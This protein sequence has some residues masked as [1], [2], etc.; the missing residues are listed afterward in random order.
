MK[1]NRKVPG[2]N[3]SSTADISFILLIFFLVTTSMDTDM[4]ITRRLPEWQPNAQEEEAKVKERNLLIVKVNSDNEILV[5]KDVIKITELKDIAK[6]FIANPENKDN[7]PAKEEYEIPG[8]GT[9]VTTTK[10]VISL[11]TDGDTQYEIYFK[12]QNELSRAYNELRDEWLFEQYHK[13]SRDFAED[14][15]EIVYAKGMYPSKI[16]EAEPRQYGAAN[17]QY[18]E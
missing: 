13:H 11:Q 18:A 15:D 10:H 1:G 4:G 2:L 17:I 5:R 3:S 14:A 16:S 12:V 9:V 8:F 6:E 7:L